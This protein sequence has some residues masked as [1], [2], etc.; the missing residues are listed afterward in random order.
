M[1]FSKVEIITGND[2]LSGLME[3]LSKPG[4]MARL[5][6]IGVS[7]ITV[8]NA[9]GC[10]VQMGTSEY[11]VEEH[12][13]MQLLPKFQIMIVCETRM[14]EELIELIKEELYTGHIGDGKIFISDVNNIVRVRTGEEGADALNKS[15]I[16]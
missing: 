9:L 11:E 15:A 10:G 4:L 12:E 5:H 16:D 1:E 14:V 2:K 13:I 8:S 6:K 7:G 3:R